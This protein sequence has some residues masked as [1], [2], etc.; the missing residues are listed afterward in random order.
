MDKQATRPDAFISQ[1]PVFL[2]EKQARA[3]GASEEEQQ[4]AAMSRSGGWKVLKEFVETIR[5]EMDE[6]NDAAIAGGAD[7]EKIGQNTLVISQTKGVLKRIID[8]VED[9]REACE[10]Q[11]ESKGE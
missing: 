9:A 6:L 3:K 10:K 5:E 7:F 8:K 2:S 11:E 4:L 1:L